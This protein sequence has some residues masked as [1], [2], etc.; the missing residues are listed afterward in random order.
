MGT[1]ETDGLIL[2]SHLGGVVRKRSIGSA[3]PDTPLYTL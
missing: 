2:A 3:S 1:G